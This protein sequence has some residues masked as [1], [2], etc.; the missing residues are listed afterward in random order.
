MAHEGVK[1][2]LQEA[3][4]FEQRTEAIETAV[5]MG[6]PLHEIEEFLDWL[7]MIERETKARP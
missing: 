7:D 2:M 3:E 6:M 4:T 5:G 1:L